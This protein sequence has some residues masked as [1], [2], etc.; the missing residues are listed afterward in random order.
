[1]VRVIWIMS[2]GAIGALMRYLVS[3]FVH[4]SGNTLFP[5]GT[6]TVNVIGA[7]VIGALWQLAEVV[8]L[9]PSFRHFWMIGLLGAFTTFSTFSLETL[10]LVRDGEMRQGLINILLMNGLTLIA[11]FVGVAIVRTFL[12]W[13][14]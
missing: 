9:P 7:C 13:V 12:S 5:W 1:M 10:S 11:V 6:L 3:A 2:G 8:T 4:Q 14:R